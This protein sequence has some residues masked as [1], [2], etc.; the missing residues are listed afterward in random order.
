MNLKKKLSHSIGVLS[1]IRHYVPKHLLQTLYYSLLNSNL[2]Y[3]C[4]IWGQK[5]TNQLFKRLLLLQEK[6]ITLINFLPQTSPSNNLFK[7]NKI[8]KISD[9]INYKYVL[10]VRN[11][12]RKENL[13][14]FNNMFTLDHTH[15]NYATTNHLLDIPQIVTSETNY[16]LWNLFYDIHCIYHLQ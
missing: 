14:I 12:L 10:F 5:Q 9:Y 1:K 11:S 8:L 2:I 15:N 7:E 16:S 6:A 13:Q 3:A 4:K